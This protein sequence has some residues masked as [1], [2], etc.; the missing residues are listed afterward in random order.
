MPAPPEPPEPPEP[1]EPSDEIK[2]PTRRFHLKLSSLYMD[3]NNYRFIDSE[4]YKKIDRDEENFRA[5]VQLRT[6]QL[7][8][9]EKQAN[10]EDLLASLQ[11]NGWLDMEPIQVRQIG[12]RYL[13]VEGNRRVATLKYLLERHQNGSP[14]G[15]LDPVIFDKVPVVRVA[16]T[17]PLHHLVIMG[18]HHISGKRQWP[19]INQA[20]LMRELRAN[21]GKSPD[22]IC[23]ALAIS[24]REFNLSIRTLALVNLY[25]KSDYGEQF[26]SDKFNLFREVLKAPALRA[27]IG[28]DDASEEAKA[29]EQLRRLFSWISREVST[30][31][32]DDEGDAGASQTLDPVVTTGTQV[33]ELA[34]IISDPETVRILDKTRSLQSASLSSGVLARNDV[35]VALQRVDQATRQLFARATTL[36][37][38]DLGRIEEAVNRLNGV[39]VATGRRGGSSV[40]SQANWTPYQEFRGANF[41]DIVVTSYRGLQDVRLSSP[42]R[43]NLIAGINN[44]GKTSLLESVF[45]LARQTDS[46]AL[47]EVVRRRAHTE[48]LPEAKVV[49][50]LLPSEASIRGSFDG[51]EA[52]LDWKIASEPDDDQTD[53]ATFEHQVKMDARYGD[54]DQSSTTILRTALAPQIRTRGDARVLCPAEF[55]SP[56]SLA[57]PASLVAANEA[58]SRTGVKAEI[59][60]FFRERFVATLE[61]IELV[62]TLSRFHVRETGRVQAEDLGSYGEGMQRVFHIAMLFANVP[63]G[64]MLID[65]FENAIHAGAF[66]PFA[67]LIQDLARRFNVQVFLSTHSAEVVDAWT[68]SEALRAEVV[69][70]GLRRAAT[71]R[72]EA[73]RFDGERLHSLKEAFSFDLR[74][75]A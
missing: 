41:D 7:L 50:A 68:S 72:I 61:G 31:A 3:P 29:H 36:E 64:V 18:L 46:R 63:G 21:Y 25:K 2:A 44:A 20:H 14:I 54:R 17:D 71:G 52:V 45:L 39:L 49:A 70:Y 53:R 5:D 75:L 38:D 22:E 26:S 62:N 67:T 57:E 69:G 65:E 24:K 59:F 32:T 37:R 43:I 55:S 40:L 27:W 34:G 73:V 74:G 16:D 56:F 58:S 28:W 15:A 47:L 1:T 9:G 10:V 6:R 60:A 23:K 19:P 4:H 33:R 8:L 11:Q 51:R 42:A 13:V 66:V 35:D 30:E 12:T 48:S